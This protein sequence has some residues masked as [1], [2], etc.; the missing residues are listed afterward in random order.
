MRDTEVFLLLTNHGGYVMKKFIK[1]HPFLFLIPIV[2]V[3]LCIIPGVQMFKMKYYMP[4]LKN[5]DS[6]YW[7]LIES[8]L[9]IK[10]PKDSKVEYASYRHDSD[11]NELYLK[12]LIPGSTISEFKSSV[13]KGYDKDVYN[14]L[15]KGNSHA[16]WYKLKNED[17]DY[18]IYRSD[19]DINFSREKNGITEVYIYKCWGRDENT[20]ELQ[21]LFDK[22]KWPYHF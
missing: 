7:S 9:E 14:S 4:T 17:Y 13:S 1:K 3:L 6:K 22:D 12:L 15:S 2:I 18:S 16:K 8:K 20:E 19:M 21:K 5:I 11:G 10:F